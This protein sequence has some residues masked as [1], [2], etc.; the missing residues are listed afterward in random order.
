MTPDVVKLLKCDVNISMFEG[1]INRKRVVAL[2][3]SLLQLF[4]VSKATKI[5]NR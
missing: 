3:N 4:G 1:R 2:L 5:K